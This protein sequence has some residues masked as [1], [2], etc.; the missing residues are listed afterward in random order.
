MLNIV[1]VHWKKLTEHAVYTMWF[2]VSAIEKTENSNLIANRLMK[3]QQDIGNYIKP[4]IGVQ[5]ANTLIRLLKEHI[6]AASNTV[7]QLLTGTKQDF[8]QADIKNRVIRLITPLPSSFEE[9]NEH[10]SLPVFK[11]NNFLSIPSSI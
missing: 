11:Q 4:M 3:N 8:K 10:M 2:I 6:S 1:N 7:T 9:F 5:N